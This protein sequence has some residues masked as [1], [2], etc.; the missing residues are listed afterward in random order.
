MNNALIME[1]GAMRGMFTCGVI[2]VLMERGITFDAA[3]G[4][5]AGAV[6]GCNF[7]SR[8]IG[9][10]IRYNKQYCAD[11][12]YCS[13]RSLLTTGDLYGADFCYQELPDALDVFDR[14]AFRDNPM[15]FYVGATD[16]EAG[17]C[18]FHRCS[19]G[20]AA[21]MAWL[22]ASASMPFMSRPVEIDGK[23]YLDGG[24]TDAVPFAYMEGL[25][26]RRCVIVLTQPKGYRK[27]PPRGLRLMRFALRR[28]PRLAAAMA[29]RHEMYN[30][31]MEEIDRREGEGIALV[32]RPPEALRIGHTE[33]RPQELERVYRIG[34]AE[35]ERRLGEITRFLGDGRPGAIGNTTSRGT[36]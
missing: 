26:C 9:R 19:D 29:T 15:A 18:V 20:G 2:D 10:P 11:P 35:T 24:I 7:K 30:R 3:A 5:S 6:F 21:D 34:R 22:R 33:K 1:G 23:Q 17:R 31:Q 25:G 36:P 13:L 4:I 32:I 27:R 16:I 14:A 8:Q 28:S 12:R